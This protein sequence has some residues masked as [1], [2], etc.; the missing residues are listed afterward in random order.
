MIS[1]SNLPLAGTRLSL[2]TSAPGSLPSRS[3]HRTDTADSKKSGESRNVGKVDGEENISD[4]DKSSTSAKEKTLNLEPSPLPIFGD[5]NPAL[6]V[7]A[8]KDG[9]DVSKK[10]KPKNN[11]LKSN[12]TFVSKVLLHDLLSRRIQEHEEHDSYVIA[13]IGRAVQ[14]LDISSTLKVCTNSPVLMSERSLI[15]SR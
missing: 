15:I 9:K 5:G 10:A 8:G 14:W 3:L 13:N 7:P 2:V 1:T 4:E 6:A 12:S 11:L